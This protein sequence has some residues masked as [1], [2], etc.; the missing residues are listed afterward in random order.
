MTLKGFTGGYISSGQSFSNNIQP[1]QLQGQSNGNNAFQRCNVRS[2]KRLNKSKRFLS[3]TP[4]KL[5]READFR[6]IFTTVL[7]HSKQRDRQSPKYGNN[8]YCNNKRSQ[9]SVKMFCTFW[10]TRLRNLR[11]YS[12][13][14]PTIVRAFYKIHSSQLWLR[15]ISASCRSFTVT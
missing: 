12:A 15:I 11:N 14:E 10:D 7:F 13:N 4:A 6:F 3:T 5:N 8:S 9:K 2:T 1:Y